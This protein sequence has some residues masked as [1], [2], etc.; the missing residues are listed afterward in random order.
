MV[1]S[2]IQDAEAS[3]FSSEPLRYP[4]IPGTKAG[5]EK[6]APTAS[7]PVGYDAWENILKART[8]DISGFVLQL[9]Y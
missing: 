4:N 9:S 5:V 3:H 6:N 1:L 2:G 7:A 8:I